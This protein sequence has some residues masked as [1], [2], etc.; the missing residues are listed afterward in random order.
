MYAGSECRVK[1]T[2]CIYQCMHT[3]CLHNPGRWTR[4]R[5]QVTGSAPNKIRDWLVVLSKL[6]CCSNVESSQQKHVE[7]TSKQWS[8]LLQCGVI[9]WVVW[10]GLGAELPMVPSHL[11]AT[12][13]TQCLFLKGEKAADS[14]EARG[15]SAENPRLKPGSHLILQ[16]PKQSVPKRRFTFYLSV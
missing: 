4:A 16:D 8:W 1:H 14:R 11:S 6:A 2:R 3:F 7:S 15:N 13:H 12:Y 9:R 5:L 10:Q